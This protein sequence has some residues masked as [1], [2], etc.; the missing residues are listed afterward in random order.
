MLVAA[1]ASKKMLK[2]GE[3]FEGESCGRSLG[4]VSKWSL[5]PA[6]PQY[7][8]H[9]GEIAAPISV[10][11]AP[12]VDFNLAPMTRPRNLSRSRLEVAQDFQDIADAI[13]GHR[14]LH[15]VAWSDRRLIRNDNAFLPAPAS[16]VHEG[17]GFCA[18]FGSRRH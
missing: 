7:G 8:L 15:G 9:L 6:T 12:E 13:F 5:P 2:V 4:A 14:G 3:D 10:L 18:L 1:Q 17:G 16:L 11:A